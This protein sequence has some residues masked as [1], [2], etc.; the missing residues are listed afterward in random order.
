M[1]TDNEQVEDRLSV[2]DDEPD[3]N[4]WVE[5]FS[6]AFLAMLG[7]YFLMNPGDVVRVDVMQWFSAAMISVGAIWAGHGLKD[8]AVKEIRHSIVVLDSAHHDTGIDLG[9]IRDVLVNPAEYQSFLLQAYEE[10]YEDGII[11]EKEMA[12]LSALQEALGLS[13]DDAAKIAARAAINLALKD[14]SVAENELKIIMDA[15]KAAKVS[16]KNCEKIMAAL[17]DGKLD[18]EEEKM[19]SELLSNM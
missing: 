12:E 7:M 1:G 10:A 16:K 4:D 11:T 18:E 8:M 2:F 13:D 19:L 3:I 6:G 15:A 5:I 9:L 14:G 17:E